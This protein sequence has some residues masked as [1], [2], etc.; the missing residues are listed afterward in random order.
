METLLQV[1]RIKGLCRA[2]RVAKLETGPKG[3]VISFHQDKFADPAGLVEYLNSSNGTAK[4]KENK[5]V[6]RR[7]WEQVEK[8]LK[9][10]H[11][12]VRDLAAIAV[13]AK[14]AAKK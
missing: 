11:V 12:I 4:V 10:A 2:A 8:R 7:D 5:L 14:K 6:V 1:V 3:A 13:A 9:G